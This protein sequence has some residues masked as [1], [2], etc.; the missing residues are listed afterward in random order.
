MA[1]VGQLRLENPGQP[2]DV[3][4]HTYYFEDFIVL[5][6][7]RT[8]YSQSSG[9]EFPRLTPKPF[10]LLLALL[11]AATEA[12]TMDLR[13]LSMK[14]LFGEVWLK[15][16]ATDHEMRNRIDVGLDAIRKALG[17]RSFIK[18]RR[19]NDGTEWGLA[20]SIEIWARNTRSNLPTR[21]ARFIG[22]QKLLDD[23]DTDFRRSH[24]LAI[25]IWGPGAFGKTQLA[26]EYAHLFSKKYR[27]QFWIDSASALEALSSVSRIAKELNLD[28]YQ[29]ADNLLPHFRSWLQTHS[30][31]LI[32]FDDVNE[33]EVIEQLLPPSYTGHVLI[34]SRKNDF[35]MVAP[36]CREHEVLTP[37]EDEALTLLFTSAGR[38]VAQGSETSSAI[39]LVREFENLPLA[40]EAAG[41]YVKKFG[42]SFRDYHR[43][44][45][46][47]AERGRGICFLHGIDPNRRGYPYSGTIDSI[48]QISRERL[49]PT[50]HSL[51][52]TY[53]ISFLSGGAITFSQFAKGFERSGTVFAEILHDA[54][55]STWGFDVVIEPIIDVTLISVRDVGTQTYRMHRL[56]QQA[57]RESLDIASQ[58]H[59]ASEAISVVAYSLPEVLHT[60]W[61]T[62]EPS[63][64]LLDELTNHAECC[65]V[66][67]EQYQ[68]T[69]EAAA[70]L[71]ERAS[72]YLCR[73]ARY[74][75]AE[76]LSEKAIN[77]R[78]TLNGPD[79]KEAAMAR[80]YAGVIQ[81]KSGKREKDDQYLSSAI[82]SISERKDCQ[83]E[84]AFL[85]R[86]LAESLWTRGR[87][88]QAEK[89]LI[90]VVNIRKEINS[91][92]SPEYAELL[93]FYGYLLIG[94]NRDDDAEKHFHEAVS[95]EQ[96]IRPNGPA[97]ALAF[98]RWGTLKYAQGE[99]DAALEFL[100]KAWSIQSAGICS[101]AAERHPDIADTYNAMAF[102]LNDMGEPEEAYDWV[103]KG[104]RIRKTSLHEKHGDLAESLN[105]A[106][107]VCLSLNRHDEAYK[108]AREGLTIRRSAL[109]RHNKASIA[110]SL[111]VLGK[112][113]YYS[114]ASR[115][116]ARAGKLF[117]RALTLQEQSLPKEHRDIA[118]TLY[119]ISI[120][121]ED[122]NPRKA[123][124]A[125]RRAFEIA[126]VVG[127]TRKLASVIKI[128]LEN[129]EPHRT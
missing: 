5:V 27:F 30:Y 92:R 87:S 126:M 120:C 104:L 122:T 95:I 66:W 24:N 68:V 106:A 12:P 48:W 78:A 118:E 3:F 60:E 11:K 77:I 42:L 14:G 128:Q 63:W 72:F 124:E 94:L 121:L 61:T 22:R 73:R 96:Q 109:N 70:T 36:G 67:I 44:Y 57:I 71:L 55:E 31:W 50:P 129:L 53:L 90:E 79:S 112:I 40:V 39:D 119:W 58:R 41:A 82:A 123:F 43:K 62:F 19:V 18:T 34:T 69:T 80:G 8:I 84:H 74:E 6:D 2:R 127:P 37:Q 32:V 9:R 102:T 16:Q 51:A 59:W 64:Q 15:T 29:S 114:T 46:E 65:A 81:L 91:V 17:T 7:E 116:A 26:L 113:R 75:G 35:Q 117:E 105:C 1:N 56:F 47:Q 98:M 54:A 108:F 107:R 115:R 28:Q 33:P 101:D 100:R 76:K 110:W 52:L 21:N 93:S 99:Y 111:Q 86:N 49:E 97:L 103:I 83:Q 25:V 45:R 89:H 10:Q 4:A 125:C 85:K 13:W 88:T 38:T 23:L 20:E